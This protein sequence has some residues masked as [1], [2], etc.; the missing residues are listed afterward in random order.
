MTDIRDEVAADVDHRS[1]GRFIG[2]VWDVRSDS[3]T[4]A[5]GQQVTRDVVVHP[6]AVGIIAL[7]DSD[8]VLLLRQYR[9]PVGMYLWEPPAGLL[10][11]P[12]EPPWLCAQRELLEEAGLVAAQW[13]TLGDWFNTPGGSTESF[14]CFLARGIGDAPGGRPPRDA[15]ERH[16]PA[17]WIALDDAVAAVLAG[18]LHNPTTVTGI[19]AA[20]SARA[21]GWADLRPHDA[22]WPARA[23][24]ERTD[25]TRGS[26][27]GGGDEPTR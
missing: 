22:P 19:L 25:R 5:D 18:R 26:T 14:R 21:R 11:S 15:E 4:L 20:Y 17:A 2:R 7:D 27:T 6:G 24:L 3:V 13:W 12:G 10:D 16:M 9:H 23:H 8:K 1:T